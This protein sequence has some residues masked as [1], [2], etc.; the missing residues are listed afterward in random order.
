[1]RQLLAAP[2]KLGR[3]LSDWLG[4][5]ESHEW[6]IAREQQRVIMMSALCSDYFEIDQLAH[7]ERIA[8]HALNVSFT[9]EFG[10]LPVTS[11]PRVWLLPLCFIVCHLV[12]SYGV[13]RQRRF[14]DVRPCIILVACMRVAANSTTHAHS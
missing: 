12:I 1:M 5:T 10:K 14:I 7:A 11:L 13:T 2:I 8:E 9:P 6:T 4:V 3:Q